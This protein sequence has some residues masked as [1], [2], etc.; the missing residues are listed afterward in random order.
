MILSPELVSSSG[1]EFA[2]DNLSLVES[3]GRGL[4]GIDIAAAIAVVL[5]KWRWEIWIREKEREKECMCECVIL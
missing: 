3:V 4:K 1:P 2:G 5:G